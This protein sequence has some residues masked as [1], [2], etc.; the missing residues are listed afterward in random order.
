MKKQ[1]LFASIL[2]C[3]QFVFSQVQTDTAKRTVITNR[4]IST[5]AKIIPAAKAVTIRKDVVNLKLQL[6]R[7]SDSLTITKK[8]IDNLVDKMKSDL[9]S[10]SEMGEMESLRL[11]M[12]M[13]RLNKMMST[14]SNILKKISDTGQQITQNIK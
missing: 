6:L 1:L 4:T 10:M 11:Q 7:M 8:E 14:L 12:A 5:K 3:T 2:L 13:D 9:D